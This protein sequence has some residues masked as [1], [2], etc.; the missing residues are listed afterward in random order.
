MDEVLNMH[1]VL[2]AAPGTVM[3]GYPHA[4]VDDAMLETGRRERK[5]KCI[6]QQTL[7][8]TL[9]RQ[10]LARSDTDIEPLS[11][12]SCKITEKFMKKEQDDKPT[13]ANQKKWLREHSKR[14]HVGS[15]DYPA[16]HAAFGLGGSDAR[17]LHSNP[18]PLLRLFESFYA[19]A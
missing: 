5:N 17:I 15:L 2:A 1:E 6:E 4:P 19:E 16:A 7:A 9:A 3:Y 8:Q 14:H 10:L 18:A 13:A 12:P 11:C